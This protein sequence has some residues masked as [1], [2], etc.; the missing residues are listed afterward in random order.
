VVADPSRGIAAATTRTASSALIE[1]REDPDLS[2]SAAGVTRP[3][4]HRIA[5]P[6]P[7]PAA[8]RAAVTG[9]ATGA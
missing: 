1:Q 4:R 7:L 2:P 8:A 6:R 3:Y 9:S 5:R